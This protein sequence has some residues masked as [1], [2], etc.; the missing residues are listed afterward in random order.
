MIQNVLSLSDKI[1][2]SFYARLVKIQRDYETECWEYHSKAGKPYAYHTIDLRSYRTNRLAYADPR[3][4]P[5]GVDIRQRRLSIICGNKLCCRPSHMEAG[6]VRFID[7]RD[8]AQPNENNATSR[9]CIANDPRDADEVAKDWRISKEEVWFIWGKLRGNARVWDHAWD[10]D[11]PSG[12]TLAKPA[13]PAELTEGRR[14]ILREQWR[15]SKAKHR[16]AVGHSRYGGR[17]TA[18]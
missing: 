2:M 17:P 12:T 3:A 8:R 1:T 4:N 7:D 16:A 5:N 15:R 9:R 13:E 18:N 6:P 10:K 11:I 14:E